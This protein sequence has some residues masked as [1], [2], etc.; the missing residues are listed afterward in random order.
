MSWRA[1]W[2]VEELRRHEDGFPLTCREKLILHV[3]AYFHDADLRYAQKSIPEIAYRALSSESQARR[4]IQSC[5][6][7]KTLY[8][9]RVRYGKRNE[10]N[11]YYFLAFEKRDGSVLWRNLSG[12]TMTPPP[13]VMVPPGGVI[14]TSKCPPLSDREELLE[15]PLNTKP[16]AEPRRGDSS[17]PS[18]EVEQRRRIEMRDRREKNEAAAAIGSRPA[19]TGAAPRPEEYGVRV[20]PE[21]L[22]RIQEREA[23][24]N[25]R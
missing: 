12:V 24:R 8:V 2:Y 6:E 15:K 18:L 9:R 20:N 22:R 10:E 16:A 21:T 19:Q 14:S 4:C 11:F 7:H 23:K 3:T 17:P 1:L 5:E 13:G 25:A